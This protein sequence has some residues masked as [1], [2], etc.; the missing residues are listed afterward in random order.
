MGTDVGLFERL[1]PLGLEHGRHQNQ[2]F[3]YRIVEKE[4]NGLP[5]LTETHFVR[6]DSTAA[7]NGI[8]GFSGHHPIHTFQLVLVVLKSGERNNEGRHVGNGRYCW[9]GKERKE[10]IWQLFGKTQEFQKL[11]SEA[12]IFPCQF[13]FFREYFL[14][15]LRV[16]R[17]FRN[18]RHVLPPIKVDADGVMGRKEFGEG[19]VWNVGVSM[20]A[21]S[22]KVGVAEGVMGRNTD[23]DGD[24]DKFP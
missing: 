17:N 13:Q 16:L 4:T 19:D 22:R 8:F 14:F 3:W 18:L 11:K 9:K 21:N 7:Q 20:G 15:F 23:G 12:S 2:S 5:G 6:Q 10:G 24:R 1:Q